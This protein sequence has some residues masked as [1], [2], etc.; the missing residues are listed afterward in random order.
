[1]WPLHLKTEADMNVRLKWI[2][3][4][5]HMSTVRRLSSE[6]FEVTPPPQKKTTQKI[7]FKNKKYAW[8]NHMHVKNRLGFK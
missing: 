5:W 3:E 6:H 7:K 1:M 8:M 4:V 2:V